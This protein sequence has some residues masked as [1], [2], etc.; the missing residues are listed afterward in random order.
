MEPD[1][2]QFFLALE[3]Q[4]WQAQVTG[5]VASQRELLPPDFLGVD[6]DGVNDLERHL[7]QL[8]DGPI[9][10]DFALSEAQLLRVGQ[11][12]VL[13]SYRADARAPREQTAETFFIT[14]L[15]QRRGD[16]WWN[17][18]SQDTPGAR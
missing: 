2:V 11:D 3:E 8:A 16:R 17:T 6:T 5:D 15:W 18:F 1:D 12:A 14:S 7:A 10:A 4:V 9:T 13:L